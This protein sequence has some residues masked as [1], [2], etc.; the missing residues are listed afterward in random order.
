MINLMKIWEFKQ[1]ELEM[2]KVNMRYLPISEIL[3]YK[4]EV[5]VDDVLIL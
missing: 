4:Q 2:Y 5:N 3:K 1:W